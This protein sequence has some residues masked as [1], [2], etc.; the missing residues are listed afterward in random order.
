MPLQLVFFAHS[1]KVPM[2][3]DFVWA[4]FLVIYGVVL[5]TLFC[6]QWPSLDFRVTDVEVLSEGRNED[7]ILLLSEGFCVS[8]DMG[9]IIILG[10]HLLSFGADKVL[11]CL[12]FLKAISCVICSWVGFFSVVSML[13]CPLWYFWIFCLSFFHLAGFLRRFLLTF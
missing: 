9:G 4:F 7:S 10:H 2:L 1:L 3:G 13:V 8:V 11:G 12:V 5:G 6:I